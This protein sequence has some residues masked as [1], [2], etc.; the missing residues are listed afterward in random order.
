MRLPPPDIE[1]LLP[2]WGERYT[3]DF[4]D[5]CLPSLLAPGNLPGLSKYGRC[6]FV[7]LA[8]ARDAG[9]VER[10]PLWVR[11]RACCAVRIR[12]IDDLISKSGSTV[13][14]LAYASAIRAAGQGALDTCFVLLVAD[15]V[16]AD[17]SL[18]AVVARIVGGA[19][20]VLAGNFQVEREI[21][22]LSLEERKDEAGVLTI[23]SRSLVELSLRALHR[24]T[25]ANIVDRC[26]WLQPDTN[27]LFWRAGERCM[28]GRFFLMHM[29]AIRPETTEFVIAAASDYSFIPELCPSGNVV[30][31][32]DSDDYFVIECQPRDGGAPANKVAR[33]EAPR[34]DPDSVA[35]AVAPWATAQHRAN[36]RH[37]LIFHADA[38]SNQAAEAV[39][40][41][42]RFVSEVGA[43]LGGSPMPSRHHPFWMRSIDYHLATA[44]VEQDPAR[45]ADMTG[46]RSLEARGGTASRWRS[47]LLGRAPHFRPWHPRWADVRRLRL[48]LDA[49]SGKAA[50][51]SD[52]SAR[53]R[54]WLD[55]AAERRGASVTHLRPEDLAGEP[56]L[57]RPNGRFDAVFLIGDR[58]PDESGALL[59]RIAALVKPQ[60]IVVLAIGDLF[61]EAESTP[62]SVPRQWWANGSGLTLEQAMCVTAGVARAA[63][64]AAMM[65]NAKSA[66]GP[67]S[68]KSTIR[69]AMASSLA[70]ASMLLNFGAV[71]R[72]GPAGLARCSSAFFFLRKAGG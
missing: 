61:S 27:R 3:R 11:L 46:D 21:A 67:V 10:D 19:S 58:L 16:V 41:A 13:L 62:V 12:C 26:E 51:I 8:P 38:I 72:R 65:R 25:L 14:T 40:A 53:V 36:A 44:R 35:K 49:V 56:A 43:K 71:A 9:T 48:V 59:A 52:S 24:T 30:H 17:G 55:A 66:I 39:A 45:L 57:D 15:Y 34:L 33:N 31:I 37:S 22:L 54:I 69:F 32:T 18:G 2:V 20:G 50:V 68:P 47:L 23:P 70:A 29:I 7:L 5:L 28:V 63:V 60:G 6:T 42:D 64:Q 1:I 4:L